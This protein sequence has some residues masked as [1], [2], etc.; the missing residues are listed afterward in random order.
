[1]GG[2]TARLL[3]LSRLV[4]RLGRPAFT[5]V[6]RVE[7]AYLRRFLAEDVPLFAL[8]RSSF[9]YTVF[10]RVGVERLAARLFGETQW[11]K[12]DLL[13]K[14]FM[15]PGSGRRGPESDLRRLAIARTGR[16]LLSATLAR[17]LPANTTWVNVGHS[18]LV[19][20][21]FDAVHALPGG[22]A[23][24]MV[25]DTIPLDH[26][27]W[28]RTGTVESFEAR[29][30]QVAG[31]ADLVLHT[32]DATRRT[33]EAQFQRFGRV[34]KG[35]TAHL[36][37][38]RPQPDKTKIPD[39]VHQNRPYFVALGTIEPRK[40]HALLLDLWA[41]LALDLPSGDVP[42]LYLVGAR[43][44][45][46]NAV[47]ARLDADP[48]HVHELGPLCD[49]ATAALIQGAQALLMPS[50]VE[51]FG[52]PPGEALALGAPV[53]AT[54]LPVYREV[55]GNNIVYLNPDHLYLWKQSITKASQLPRSD[56]AQTGSLPTWDEHFNIALNC[57]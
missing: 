49:G 25:H 8:V 14:A 35:T 50:L 3:D 19:Y 11:G 9:G 12:P 34:P 44:W 1:M 46:N 15:K 6:D 17:H 23:V 28:Q 45:N 41:D 37:I 31:K 47:F 4:S 21:V 22:R 56:R 57:L 2:D 36:G 43:G 55:F 16:R 30:R 54:D 29:M 32:A 52:L 33:N 7:A 13:T 20:S 48:A 40:N 10:D 27:D 18:N 42:Q 5:G 51:G 38:E 26:P 53:I 24:V 39:G